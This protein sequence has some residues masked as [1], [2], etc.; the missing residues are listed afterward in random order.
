MKHRNDI[1]FATTGSALRRAG[2]MRAPCTHAGIAS[3]ARMA[4][5]SCVVA[6]RSPS[7]RLVMQFATAPTV[8][9]AIAIAALSAGNPAMAAASLA[10]AIAVRG[11]PAF[12][13]PPPSSMR[14][15]RPP[16]RRPRGA[17]RFLLFASP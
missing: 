8:A 15:Q 17:D 5:A 2:R 6:R 3:V 9:I 7:L 16:C 4:T 14:G 13:A 11:A 1:R 10:C 12:A